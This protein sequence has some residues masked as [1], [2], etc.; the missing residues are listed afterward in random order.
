MS[1]LVEVPGAQLCA[2]QCPQAS[3]ITT[4]SATS[5]QAQ[6]QPNGENREDDAHGR[7]VIRA[8]PAR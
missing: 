2:G 8:G 1:A 3:P 4:S 5:R 7:K 6:R